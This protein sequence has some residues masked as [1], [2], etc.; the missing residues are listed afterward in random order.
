[1]LEYQADGDVENLTTSVLQ[2][3]LSEH[4]QRNRRYNQVRLVCKAGRW[5]KA[6]CTSMT[7]ILDLMRERSKIFER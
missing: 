3:R 5:Q 1:V 7:K 4:R 2:N 6:T